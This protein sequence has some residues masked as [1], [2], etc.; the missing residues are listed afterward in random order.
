[1]LGISLGGL[2]LLGIV[3]Y[4]VYTLLDE[5]DKFLL[6]DGATRGGVIALLGLHKVF[7]EGENIIANGK[8]LKE[9]KTDLIKRRKE[10]RGIK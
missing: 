9:Y 3:G 7:D 4:I 1:M 8:P 5:D 10:E 6:K 2:I